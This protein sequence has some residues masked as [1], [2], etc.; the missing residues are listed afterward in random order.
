MVTHHKPGVPG[1]PAWAVTGMPPTRT[2]VGGTR[3]KLSAK[4][5]RSHERKLQGQQQQKP[6]R[7][8]EGKR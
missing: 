5:R 3:M 7:K 4:D 8:R 1:V 6:K 2:E